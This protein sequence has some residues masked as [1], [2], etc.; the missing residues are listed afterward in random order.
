MAMGLK[1]FPQ[2]LSRAKIDLQNDPFP[3]LRLRR[4]DVKLW[5]ETTYD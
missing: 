3:H 2:F 5:R 4:F 1:K